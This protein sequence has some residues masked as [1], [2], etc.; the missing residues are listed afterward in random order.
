MCNDSQK[1]IFLDRDGVINKDI[2]Y[3]FRIEDFKFE[4]KI[5]DACRHF[6]SIGYQLIII[7]N[8][9]GIYRKLYSLNDFLKLNA[10]M[11][12]QFEHNGV[13]IL[14]VYFCSH[15]PN[16]NC[17]CRKP[18]PGMILKAKDKHNVNMAE[19]W[20]IGD[21][22]TDISSAIAA[23][24]K[25]TILITGNKQNDPLESNAKFVLKS[26]EE[27]LQIIDK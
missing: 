4:K 6:N 19:S 16:S 18:K 25:N 27:C 15:G 21:K 7:T 20:L 11:L 14:D 10:W 2:G 23:N 1:V 17:S 8:Q 22:E 5:F 24:I 13:K 26:I 3:L 12:D 9:S